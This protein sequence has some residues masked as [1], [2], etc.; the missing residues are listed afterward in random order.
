MTAWVRLPPLAIVES[1]AT[2]A[3][4]RMD[5]GPGTKEA[6]NMTAMR[7]YWFCKTSRWIFQ[8]HSKMV[9][10]MLKIPLPIFFAKSPISPKSMK[11][12]EGSV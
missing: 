12:P 4:A 6:A 3:T 2:A 1:P 10:W 8:F 7:P 5:Q 9:L 11:K